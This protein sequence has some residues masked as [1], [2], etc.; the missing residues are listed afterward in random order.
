MK[1]KKE[2]YEKKENR[3]NR[4]QNMV[5]TLGKFQV[6]AQLRGYAGGGGGICLTSLFD[7]EGH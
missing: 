7:N 3:R 6:Y 4:R 5:M 2:I 1:I